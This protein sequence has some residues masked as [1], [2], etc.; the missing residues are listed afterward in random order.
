MT[1]VKI[2]VKIELCIVFLNWKF[3]VVLMVVALFLN[4][5]D[6]DKQ[7]NIYSDPLPIDKEESDSNYKDDTNKFE[8]IVVSNKY[9]Q[10]LS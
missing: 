7:K 10:L 5:F 6:I 4:I 9:R 1:T 2:T 3:F 8:F